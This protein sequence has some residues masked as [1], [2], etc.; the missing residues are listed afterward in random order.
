MDHVSA[1]KKYIE[2]VRSS[3]DMHFVLI[4]GPPGWGK[5]TA[6]DQALELAGIEGIHLGAYSTPLNFYNFL[7]ENSDRMIVIDDCAG[8]LTDQSSM[9]LLKAATWAQ[10]SNKRTVK[11][12]S[13]SSK[14]SASEFEFKGKLILACNSFPKTPDS[15]AIRSRGYA[16][17]IEM[18]VTEAKEL[19][20]TAA[21]DARWFKSVKTAK[22][23][24]EFLIERLGPASLPK[25]S[26]RTLKIGYELAEVHPENWKELL[27]PLLPL[28]PT[29]PIKLIKDL[30]KK[31]MKVKDQVRIFEEQTGL[32]RRSFFIY[33]REAQL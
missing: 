26:Y 9:A 16:W 23:V 30:S 18:T 27:A 7:Y 24:A 20:L 13:T 22:A 1:I 4:E 19:L 10:R 21:K 11:W 14:A 12:G 32:K 17:R 5:T 29:D 25:I 6:I 31:Q 2:V 3:Q 28:T 15:E 33:R 8:L